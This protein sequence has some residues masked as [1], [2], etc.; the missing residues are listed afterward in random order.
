[1]NET[2]KT[3]YNTL[4]VALALASLS[5]AA[6]QAQSWSLEDCINY[7]TENNLTVKSQLLSRMSAEQSITDARSRY[8]P[9]ISAG[10]SQNWSIGRGLTAENTYAN[11]NTSSF[12][13]NGGLSLP[14]FSGLSTERQIA[15]AKANLQQITEQY[16][17]AKE[18][19]SINVITAYLQVLYCEEMVEVANNQVALSQY[20]YTRQQALL[21]AGKIPEVDLLEA[22]SQLAN[23]QYSVVQCANDLTL[24]KIDLIQL[25]QLRVEAS[26]FDVKPLSEAEALIV[27]PG[28][29]YALALQ[30][31]HSIAAAR[32]GIIASDKNISLAKAGYLPTLSFTT[33][34]GSTYYT[35]SGMKSESFGRQM[36]HNLSTSFGFSLNVPIFDAFSTR[37]SVRRAKIDKLNAELNLDQAEQQLYRSIQQAYYQA[38]GAQEKKASS[39]VAEESA[40]AAFESMQEKYNIG[41]ATPTEYE[42]SKNTALRCTAE[43]I[44]AQYELILRSRLLQYYTTPH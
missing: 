18:D 19:I 22:K 41:R 44:Q 13:W 36:D 42:Q 15:Y 20:E 38:V 34:I 43:R 37:N 25:L 12:S 24:A 16:E 27:E 23:D 14:L 4:I 11:Q 30:Y 3:I 1:M 7:A 31:N 5:P 2:M 6:A 9:Q 10:A 35:L 33:G 26:E 8:L 40:L 39:M 21:E 17:A 32:K 28:E 29:A